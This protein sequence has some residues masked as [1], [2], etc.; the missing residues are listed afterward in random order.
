[1]LTNCFCYEKRISIHRFVGNAF[2]GFGFIR[3]VVQWWLAGWR[4]HDLGIGVWGMV[5][6]PLF[7][8]HLDMNKTCRLTATLTLTFV[9]LSLL[10]IIFI[11]GICT[12]WDITWRIKSSLFRFL[13]IPSV[14]SFYGLLSIA[15]GV[16]RSMVDRKLL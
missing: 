3:P 12:H 2:H 6:L 7:V 9:W 11:Y 8:W 10:S 13:W 4:C 15:Q 5:I 16:K 1:M 14:I